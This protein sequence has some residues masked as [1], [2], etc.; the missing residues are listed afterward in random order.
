MRYSK[1]TTTGVS[2]SPWLPLENLGDQFSVGFGCVVTGTATYTIE[3]TFDN[4]LMGETATVFANSSITGVTANKDGN[5]NAPI[6]AMR[7]TITAG[8]GTVTV[9]VIQSGQGG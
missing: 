7:V 4:V 3:Y 9:K 5:F 1:I 6:N 8:T 2:S